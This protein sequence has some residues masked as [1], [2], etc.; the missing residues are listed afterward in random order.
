[1]AD[2]P[3]VKAP[4]QRSTP[5]PV[6]PGRTRRLLM[7]GAAS[8]AALVVVGGEDGG[9]DP[10]HAEQGHADHRTPPRADR[11]NTHA[12]GMT[13]ATYQGRSTGETISE[14]N[15]AHAIAASA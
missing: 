7:Y 1:M 13:Q 2:K 14:I 8:L 6:D 10:G 5:K 12:R 11:G 9:F 3:R 4:K 15:A